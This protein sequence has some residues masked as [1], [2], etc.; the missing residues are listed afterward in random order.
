MSYP[1]FNINSYNYIISLPPFIVIKEK[2]Y[3][4]I[5]KILKK[6]IKNGKVKYLIK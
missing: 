5:K 3:W 1:R 4:K 6:Q 2:E